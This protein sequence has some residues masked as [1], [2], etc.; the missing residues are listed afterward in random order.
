MIKFYDK[1]KSFYEFSN[2]YPLPIIVNGIEYSS[3]EVYFQSMKFNTPETQEYSNLIV[4]CDSPQKSKDMGGQRVNNRGESWL[5]NKNKPHLGKVNDAIRKFKHLK[6]RSDWNE[7]KDD[8]MIEAV[9][10][11]FKQNPTLKKLLINT[12]PKLIKEDSPIDNY[13]GGTHNKLG[14]ILVEV[15]EELMK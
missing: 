15:R 6:L 1:N 14:K 11:K 4:Q 3:S 2:Y 13:W 9:Y 12:Y 7:I 8:I 5:I 10:Y